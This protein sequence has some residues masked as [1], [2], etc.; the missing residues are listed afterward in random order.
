[1]REKQR[2]RAYVHG[3]SGREAERLHDQANA[4]RHL[5]HDDTCYAPESL[6]LESGCGV[7]AQTAALAANS[8]G[9]HFIS[10]DIEPA[11]LA[12]A[13]EMA[14]Q[15][16]FQNVTFINGDIFS[17]PF[18]P[19]TFDHVFVCFVLEHLENPQAALEKLGRV[20]KPGGTI[21]VMEGDHGS[22]YWHPETQESVAAWK[23][24]VSVQAR[25]SGDSLIGRRLY[26]LLSGAGFLDV[27]VSPRMVYADQSTPRLQD[28]F[29]R[30]TIIPMVEGVKEKALEWRL[31]DA[32]S[33]ARGIADLH[34]T[35]DRPDGTF[36]YTFFKA[37]ARKAS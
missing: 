36:C 21:T 4:V 29:V 14:R 9:A 30:K 3:Y 20:L 28:A 16:S 22:C 10:C 33:W 37:V 6:V 34:Q 35:A 13:R 17:L 25:T 1:M 26:P 32:A 8:P 24:L 18:L 5:L 27:R 2:Q 31:M 12:Q 11:S 19:N 15:N 23:C 7:G